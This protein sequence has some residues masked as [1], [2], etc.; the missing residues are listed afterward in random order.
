M[1]ICRTP[2]RISF[3][4]GSTDYPEWYRAHGGATLGTAINKYCY[5][6][7][8]FLPPFFAHRIRLVYS[9]IEDCQTVSDI[10]HPAARA[11]LDH[12]KF[13]R[14][15]E[16]H[17]DADLPARS[18]IGSSSAFTVGL[19]QAGYALQGHMASQ[20]QL[21]RES[22]HIEQD[23]LR[24]TVGSQ[25]QVLAAYGGFNHLTFSRD[26][27]IQVRP[28]TIS[29]ERIEL[30]ESHLMLFFTGIARTASSI[31]ETYVPHLRDGVHERL[32]K[33]LRAMVD[34]GLGILWDGRDIDRFG[35]LLHAA[36][37]AK[38]EL[39]SKVSNPKVD[40]IYQHALRAGATGGKL[41]GA[42]GGGFLLLFV[43]PSAQLRVR[44]ELST[45]IHVPFRFQCGG[46]RIIFVAP[47]E[48]Y[49]AEDGH[50]AIQNLSSFEE[51]ADEKV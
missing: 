26:G 8:R 12:L 9:V 31:A 37:D 15:L 2:F 35:T 48:D 18:G 21:S 6:T 20:E 46:S 22:I 25:D 5:I 1:I 7:C 27:D 23:V 50:R 24:E 42:G 32:M 4:G 29:R 49:A 28:V 19:L 11:V 38:R 10:K 13:D 17:H 44:K 39:G 43:P 51:I 34:E 3:F 33:T 16:I 45:L 36:W 41:L 47:E 14:G 30:L 40:F